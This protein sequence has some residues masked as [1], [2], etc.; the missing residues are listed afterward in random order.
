MEAK[1]LEDLESLIRTHIVDFFHHRIEKELDLVSEKQAKENIHDDVYSA[2]IKVESP[3]TSGVLAVKTDRRFLFNTH[4][5]RKY[6][7]DLEE[8]DYLDWIGEIVN[9]LLGNMKN[10]LITR[11]ISTDLHQPIARHDN[12]PFEEFRQSGHDL[13]VTYV[14]NDDFAIEAYFSI[15]IL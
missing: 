3:T 7:E 1:Q 4:P 8:D 12:L 2:Q 15:N 5:E 6:G 14:G 9:R 11:G 13:V 10:E